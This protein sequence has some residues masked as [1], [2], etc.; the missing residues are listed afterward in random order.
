MTDTSTRK[1]LT[2]TVVDDAQPAPN[3]YIVWDSRLVGFGLRV[4][5]SGVKTYIVRYRLGSGGRRAPIRQ[6]KIGRVGDAGL[7]P[8]KAY[9]L[10]VVRLAEAKTGGD[11]QGRRAA[12]RREMTVAELLADYEAT[13]PA[14]KKASTRNIDR[15]RI[16]RHIKPL[17]GTLRVSEVTQADIERVKRAVEI[18]SFRTDATNRKKG[19][20]YAAARTVGLLQGVFGYAKD[21]LKLIEANPAYGVTRAKDKE[22][23][24][25]LSTATIG[26]LTEIMS[27]MAERPREGRAVGNLVTAQHVN[28]IRL[29]LLCGARKNEIVRLRWTEVDLTGFLRLDDT[30]TGQKV[31]RLGAGAL[32]LLADLAEN[33]GKQP[34]VFP[35]PRDPARPVR[36]IDYAWDCIRAEAG[37]KHVRIHDLRHTFASVG[38]SGGLSLAFIGKLLGHTRVQTT[39]RYAHL[40]DDPVKGAADAISAAIDGAM[41]GKSAKI[42]NIA[43][44]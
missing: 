15:Y 34:W 31:L 5:P 10:A 26:R 37:L 3:R 9:D 22:R 27:T 7:T 1:R 12:E 33:R 23:A 4:E 44:R 24:E 38:I 42:V 17:I 21:G 11:P 16:A 41:T 32:T 6:F 39:A 19:G 14:G 20:L 29:L 2:K 8:D 35:D 40:M 18:G 30:K 43:G 13:N 36:N 25:F 28:V